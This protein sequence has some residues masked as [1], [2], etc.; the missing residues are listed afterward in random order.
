MK[1]SLSGVLVA[2]VLATVI[3]VMLWFAGPTQALEITLPSPPSSGTVGATYSFTAKVSIADAELLPIQSVTLYIYKSDDRANY[4]ATCQ[5][6]P[7]YSGSRSYSDAETNDG[8]AVVTAAGSNWAYSY[9]YGYAAW[10]STGY[11]FFPPGGYGYGYGPGAASITYQIVWTV[12]GDWLAGSYQIEVKLQANGTTFTRTSSSFSLAAPAGGGGGGGAVGY[13]FLNEY[14]GAGGVLV[15]DAEAR[16]SDGRARLAIPRGSQFLTREGFPGSFISIIEIAKAD[17]PP[18]PSNAYIIGMVYNF[19]PEG[20]TFEPPI[21]LTFIYDE[22]R[23]SPGIDEKDLTAAY[24]D[25]SRKEWVVLANSIVDT[26]TNTVTGRVSHFSAFAVVGYVPALPTPIP[27]PSPT[28]VPTSLPAPAAFAVSNLTIS[29]IEPIAGEPV[30]IGVLVTNTGSLSGN[31]VLTL[32]IDGTIV[33]SRQVTLPGEASMK[34]N[35]TV[36]KDAA[37]IYRVSVNGLAGAFTVKGSQPMPARFSITNLSVIPDRV[38]IGEEV[39]IGVTVSNVGDLAGTTQVTL[40]VD[41]AVVATKE[42]TMPGKAT[43]QI[44]FMLSRD[45][46]GVYTV[47]IGGVSGALTV[48]A[49]EEPPKAMEWWL[50]G[51]IVAAAIAVVVVLSLTLRRERARFR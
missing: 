17:Q 20:A 15:V 23:L 12:P 39:K 18:P 28:S 24:W 37:G 48:E 43:Q 26:M 27:T 50:I 7:L 10:Q 33:D 11:R 1:R 22:S 4:Q 51:G 30:N 6:L 34:V 44:G 5:D 2:V 42:V 41:N 40:K 21:A 13:T 47:D 3:G 46:P 38:H 35:F 25:A 8:S 31:H 49:V 19:G 16:S 45:A 9:G 29:P 36:S 14:V 32:E